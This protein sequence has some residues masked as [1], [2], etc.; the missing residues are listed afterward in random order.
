MK[1]DKQYPTI[2]VHPFLFLLI[3]ISF[4]T[5]TFISLFIILSIVVIH[6]LGHVIMA[7]FFKWR[8][9]RI[10]F[11]IFGGVM[12]TDEHG[13]RPLH[14]EL[15]V[16]LAGPF[17]HVF[18]Y[19]LYYVLYG[20][21]LLP[22]SIL[23][24]LFFYNTVILA[25]NLLPIW[26]LDGGKL[27]LFGLALFF[28]FRKAY[29]QVLVWSVFACI[30]GLLTLLIIYPLHL[31][32]LFLIIFLLLENISEWR[33]RYYVFMRF[34]LNRYKRDC[35][36]KK[37]KALIVNNSVRLIDI[38]HLFHR[39]KKHIVYVIFPGDTKKVL[40]ESD[41]LRYYFQKKYIYQPIGDFV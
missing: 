32:L 41:C 24:M 27:L 31:T 25:F 26:P 30:I 39:D 28:P 11:W 6:E 8:V 7:M 13:T 12:E 23:A 17:Q 21:A 15:L 3:G 1:R 19:I 4:V 40:N 29:H 2:Y 16:T 20:L 38:F 22:D 33:G 36:F 10:M 18:I 37:T 5:G 9:R 34:L 35:T 14:E